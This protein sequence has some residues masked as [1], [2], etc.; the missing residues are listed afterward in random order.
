MATSVTTTCVRCN[1]TRNFQWH[2]SWPH[3]YDL[4]FEFCCFWKLTQTASYSTWNKC[5]SISKWVLSLRNKENILWHLLWLPRNWTV[6]LTDIFPCRLRSLLFLHL[7]VYMVYMLVCVP[8]HVWGDSCGS[9]WAGGW[10]REPSS[11]ALHS[12]HW[13]RVSECSSEPANMSSPASQFVPG[14]P[15][16]A[17]AVLKL[18]AGYHTHLAFI[19]VLDTWPSVPMLVW[20]ESYQLSRLPSPLSLLICPCS[21]ELYLSWLIHHFPLASLWT[22]QTPVS[23][24]SS[25]SSHPCSL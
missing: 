25:T 15:P 5:K 23:T 18:Q 11:T 10:G 12:S 17:L 2:H 16:S 4:E 14:S 1:M 9:R 19:W 20:Q 6:A 24:I 7:S 8:A 13:G 22:P 3:N 21:G